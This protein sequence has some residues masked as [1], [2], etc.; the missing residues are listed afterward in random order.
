MINIFFVPGMFGSTLEYMLRNYTEEHDPLEGYIIDDGSMHSFRKE[1]HPGS[2]SDLLS[3]YHP[4]IKISTPIY[5]FS[6]KKLNEILAIWP[7]DLTTSKNIFI[8]AEDLHSAELNMLFQYHKISKGIV[9]AG[10]EIFCGNNTS[11]ITNWNEKYSH[12]S[13]MEVWEIRE[14][15][16]LFYPEWVSEWINIENSTDKINDKLIVNNKDILNNISHVFLQI[17][18]YCELTLKND[19]S[20]FIKEWREKQ[21]YIV[22]E[23]NLIDNIVTST[24]KNEYFNWHNCRL[25]IISEAIIQKRLRDSGYNIKCYNLNTFPTNSA[26]LHSIIE[27][28]L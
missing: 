3:D 4:D 13:Q 8:R 16:S 20:S 23:L 24:I 26:E 28:T 5:P 1:Y 25:S 2:G 12:W 27:P 6:E 19:Y 10:L 17:V 11:L 9:N 21:Q 14:W 22:D 15:L 18:E 7:G